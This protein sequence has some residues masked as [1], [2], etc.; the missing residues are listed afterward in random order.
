M[1]MP[2]DTELNNVKA[3]VAA[4]L[5]A[6]DTGEIVLGTGTWVSDL[7]DVAAT[8]K[9]VAVSLSD[10]IAGLVDGVVPS[11]QLYMFSPDGSV[12]QKTP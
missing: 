11:G 9:G 10:Y 3:G 4:M 6:S 2:A 8:V 12:Q 7:K 5:A 1:V